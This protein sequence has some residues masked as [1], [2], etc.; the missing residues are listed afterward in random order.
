[1]QILINFLV[2]AIKK[3]NKIKI[4]TFVINY[5]GSVLLSDYF[6]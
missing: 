2:H 3:S 5:K 6:I 1:M 4:K